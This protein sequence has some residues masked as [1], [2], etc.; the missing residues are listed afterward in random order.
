MMKRRNALLLALLATQLCA[1][2]GGD[3]DFEPVELPQQRIRASWDYTT[4]SETYVIRSEAQWE[5]TWTRHQPRSPGDVRPQIDFSRFMVLGITR[6]T[7][8]SG[9]FD[10]RITKVIETGDD[11]RVEFQQSRPRPGSFCTASV[12]PLTDFVIVPASS[13]PVTFVEKAA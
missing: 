12:E 6:G 5:A 7:A 2:G 3:G 4:L 13:K 9:C 10:V 1:C 8:S 11:I